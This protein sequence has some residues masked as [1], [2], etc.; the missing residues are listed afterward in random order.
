[1]QKR[2]RKELRSRNKN[3]KY[4]KGKTGNCTRRSTGRI[5]DSKGHR[6]GAKAA[7][8]AAAREDQRL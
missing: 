7:N 1:M 2:R 4:G 3:H 6:A 5:K 8:L